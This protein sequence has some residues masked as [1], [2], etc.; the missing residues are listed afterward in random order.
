V[1]GKLNRTVAQ[2][3]NS[4]SCNGIYAP[5][6][7]A[8]AGLGGQA[9]GTKCVVGVGGVGWRVQH[10]VLTHVLAATAT[11]AALSKY[12]LQLKR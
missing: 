10:S 5:A 4:S 6:A 2:S 3:A 8:A 11:A 12:L 1:V 9:I 7:A